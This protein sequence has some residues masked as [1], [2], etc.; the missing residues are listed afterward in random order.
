MFE[1]WVNF[2]QE[3]S[4]FFLSQVFILRLCMMFVAFFLEKVFYFFRRNF[5]G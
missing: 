3:I 1:G 5:H 4:L 2:I